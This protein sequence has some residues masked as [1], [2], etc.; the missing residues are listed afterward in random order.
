MSDKPPVHPDTDPVM[1]HV[2]PL[3]LAES[4][5][6]K[7]LLG[8]LQAAGVWMRLAFLHAD[9]TPLSEDERAQVRALL[10]DFEASVEAEI[11]SRPEPPPAEAAVTY[12]LNRCQTDAAF[13]R[14]MGHTQSFR[15]LCAAEAARTGEDLDTV[16]NRRGTPAARGE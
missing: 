5:L 7:R 15:L 16:M 3:A 2:F 13:W 14:V 9:C 12:L 11:P 8:A 4:P 10:G 1:F 6:G